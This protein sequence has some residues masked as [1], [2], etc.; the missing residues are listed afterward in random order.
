MK[1]N[2]LEYLTI[3]Q[4]KSVAEITKDMD[5]YS[6]LLKYG[7]V[8]DG[9]TTTFISFTLAE[10]KDDMKLVSY[11]MKAF[12]SIT[13]NTEV[14]EPKK[15]VSN[16]DII[17]I[18]VPETTNLNDT[19]LNEFLNDLNAKNYSHVAS[20]TNGYVWVSNDFEAGTSLTKPKNDDNIDYIK[21]SSDTI[22]TYNKVKDLVEAFYYDII[23][24]Q[25]LDYIQS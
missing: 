10:L 25:A 19:V 8:Y 21:A 23:I 14:T 18:E 15:N 6:V 5:G 4:R 11:D 20:K 2:P 7:Y 3:K 9:E 1:K 16:D 13:R 22:E 24:E 12:N 17:V